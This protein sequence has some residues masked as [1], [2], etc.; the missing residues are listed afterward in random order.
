MSW[1]HSLSHKNDLET[2]SISVSQ[3]WLPWTTIPL[4]LPYQGL[5]INTW[6]TWTVTD[7]SQR[8]SFPLWNHSAGGKVSVHL[9]TCACVCT[10]CMVVFWWHILRQPEIFYIVIYIRL[11]KS[12][13]V[14]NLIGTILTSWNRIA[15]KNVGCFG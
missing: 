14:N 5:T 4:E 15:R 13:V 10:P 7:A 2:K 3:N 12:T 6:N 9:C 1:H 11:K 8:N